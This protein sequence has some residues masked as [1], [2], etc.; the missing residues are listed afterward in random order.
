MVQN[1]DR[2]MYWSKDK[3]RNTAYFFEP[4]MDNEANKRLEIET[5]RGSHSSRSWR[6]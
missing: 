1:A 6:S 3:G 5:E 4:I 2:A